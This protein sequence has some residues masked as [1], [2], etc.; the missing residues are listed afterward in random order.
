MS[1]VI[2]IVSQEGEVDKS[3]HAWIDRHT[4]RGQAVCA[5]HEHEL[6]ASLLRTDGKPPILR[7]IGPTTRQGIIQSI[8]DEFMGVK[9]NDIEEH[10]YGQ[11]T[12]WVSGADAEDS[13][14]SAFVENVVAAGV[15]ATIRRMGSR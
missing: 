4:V 2:C 9:V 7:D 6:A 13:S 8:E 1:C 14:I 11:I 5:E 12:I 10:A 3:N 15:S